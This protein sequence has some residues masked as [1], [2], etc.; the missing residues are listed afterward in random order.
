MYNSST[1]CCL[2][3][4]CCLATIAI[5]AK[6][7]NTIEVGKGISKPLSFIEN[8]G[9]IMDVNRQVRTDIQY[10]LTATGMNLFVG[11]GQLNYEFKKIEG[12]KTTNTSVS[13]YMMNVCLLGANKNAEVINSEAQEYYENYFLND[14]NGAGFTAHSYNKITYKNIYPNIDW[15][16]YVKENKVEYDFIIKKGAN[17][18]DIKIAYNGANSLSINAN[19]GITAVT[20]MGI[21]E[22]KSPYSYET[23]TGKAVASHFK[24]NNNIISFETESYSGTLTIDP[25]LNWSTYY[26]GT[27]ED[28][29]TSVVAG[30]GNVLYVG[31]YTASNA[32]ITTIGPG[33]GGGTYDAFLVKYNAAGTRVWA[34]YFGGSGDDEATG[35]AVD[36]TGVVYL[37]GFSNSLGG[38]GL[39]TPFSVQQTT[40]GGGYDAF[41][42][43]FSTTGAKNWATFF[44]GTGDDK[45]YAVT[46][47]GGNNVYI[48]GTT[49]SPNAAAMATAGAYQG[50]LSG[51]TDGFIAKFTTTGFTRGRVIWS[52][53]F[54]GSSQEDIFGIHCDASNN[55]LITGQTNSSIAI[56][57]GG[58]FQATLRG[59]NDAFVAKFTSGGAGIWGTYFGG[60]G[61]E[62]GNGITTDALGNVTIIGNTTSTAN[63]ATTNA[64][65]TTLGGVQDAFVAQFDAN[66]TSEI[67]GTYYGGNLDDYGQCISIDPTGNYVI[68]G[69][70]YSTSGIA[71]AGSYQTT[72]G[73]DYDAFA[74]KLDPMGRRFWGT[75]FGSTFYEYANG[76][77][78]DGA[79]QTTMVGFTSSTTSIA[80]AGAAQGAYGGGTHD[81]FITQFSKDTLVLI[82]QPYV[83]TLVCAGGT[84]TLDYNVNY[85]FNLTN[86][87]TA[88]LSNAAGSF[89]APTTIGTVTSNTA[90]TITCT[91]PLITAPGTG[92]RIRIVASSPAVNAPDD[93]YNIHIINTPLPTATISGTTPVCVGANISLYDSTA[94]YIVTSYSWTNPGGFLFST[95]YNPIVFGVA[96]TDSGWYYVTTTHN[97]CAT[98]LDSILI[99][100]NSFIPPSPW[101]SASTPVCAGS[102]MYLFARPGMTG[103]FSYTW[104]G[105]LGFT[106]TLQNPTI[107]SST[108]ANAGTY[109]VV[110]SFQGC[111]S[112]FS[113]IDVIVNPFTPTSINVTVSPN[114]TAC[115]GTTLTFTTSIT[116]G[117]LDPIYQWMSA[118]PD[119]PIVG[120]VF[121]TYSSDHLSNNEQIFCVFKS[122][123]ECPFPIWDTSN[124]ITLTIVD[125]TPIVYLHVYPDSIV[126]PG[127]NLL[128]TAF[129][130]NA[131]ATITYKWYVN[132][133][134]VPWAVSD[135]FHLNNITTK[136]SVYCIATTIANCANP[137][138][139]Y[140]NTIVTHFNNSISNQTINIDNITLF[141]NP[142][143]GS[144]AI[145][146]YLNG[147][148]ANKM[149]LEVLNTL[150]QVVYNSSFTIQN[151]EIYQNISL[152]TMPDGI[153]IVRLNIDGQTKIFKLN[154]QK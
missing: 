32:G 20:P 124:K 73:G 81:G 105:P 126:N 137:A 107:P 30:I 53:Y 1:K 60:T 135:T 151:Q 44:G 128:F 86:V 65:K 85:N 92:Y 43:Q 106:S 76:I 50:A 141:P 47:D 35:V 83:D 119:T 100:V 125:N 102:T 57:T 66:G 138:F 9:Q 34:L 133:V 136:D 110:D 58:A 109:F 91:I 61:A 99:Q 7:T 147:S 117:G 29:A 87:F 27:A 90:G 22:E 62:Q 121:E 130:S 41:V 74:A 150:G 2:L 131:G 75:Y 36:G 101:D 148:N 139:G 98:I 15:V 103:S 25:Y 67:W 82:N 72:M 88:Q 16:L 115:K 71:T 89:A 11:K 152:D 129:V 123:I 37:A 6:E 80:S 46:C 70:T 69:M 31:G 12:N 33:Y 153:Y 52:T 54:G 77:T 63:I 93:Y 40:N 79:G 143:N 127:A 59:P 13:T 132:N 28:V 10:K 45:A 146:G 95:V 24:I 111:A 122:S 97:G 42:A 23:E 3:I 140:S 96:T 64:F 5:N 38:P 56:A 116:N 8:K 154:I 112:N 14:L 94:S 17:V 134:L 145:K 26:G 49:A 113:T 144:F 48:A 120:A 18:N 39:M 51:T 4:L 108:I 84:L 149:N 68:G 118:I 21:V 114:D 19:G 104:F 78:V 142:N 55:V